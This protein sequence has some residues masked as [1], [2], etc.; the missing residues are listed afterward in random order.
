MK[1]NADHCVKCGLCE[2]R[3]PY[4]LPIRDMLAKVSADMNAL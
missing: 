4:E 2:T 1:R 3:C